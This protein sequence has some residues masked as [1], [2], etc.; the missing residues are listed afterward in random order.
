[1]GFEVTYNDN[2][3]VYFRPP[4]NVRDLASQVVRAVNGHN[5]MKDMISTLGIGLPPYIA[6]AE[7][8]KNSI[9]DPV[10]AASTI[11]AYSMIP[12]YSSRLKHT[13]SAK[14]HTATS[15]KEIDYQ[16]LKA[17]F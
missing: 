15:S 7:A 17:R 9:R 4:G 16:Q 6:A 11:L 12:Y 13:D 8:L 5:R 3:L 10:G 14:W 2:A 1:M